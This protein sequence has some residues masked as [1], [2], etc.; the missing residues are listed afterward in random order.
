M[1]H[2]DIQK[3]IYQLE[4]V[5]SDA[6]NELEKL[7]ALLG[8]SIEKDIVNCDVFLKGEWTIS[9]NR[10]HKD[11]NVHLSVSNVNLNDLTELIGHDDK[12]QLTE[13]CTIKE[14]DGEVN[15]FFEHNTPI[16]DC[17]EVMKK[18]NIKLT[19]MFQAKNL[20]YNENEVKN[21]K[22]KLEEVDS[23]IELVNEGN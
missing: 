11:V 9:I 5:M 10:W 13:N 20:A 18:F 6:N 21:A 1:E 16:E 22:I 19:N 12:Y 17:I 14:H 23:I 3:R 15:V 2:K 7:Q 8:N 4:M